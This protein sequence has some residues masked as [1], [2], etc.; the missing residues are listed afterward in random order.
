AFATNLLLLPLFGLLIIPAAL[1]GV[2]LSPLAA[3]LAY[4][5]LWLSNET[6]VGVIWLLEWLAGQVV[7]WWPLGREWGLIVALALLSMVAWRLS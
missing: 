7:L 3:V 4:P 6:L 1:L 5:L 2:L